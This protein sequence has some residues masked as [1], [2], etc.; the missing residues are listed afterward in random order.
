MTM[1]MPRCARW[2]VWWLVGCGCECSHSLPTVWSLGVVELS[3]H[4]SPPLLTMRTG[5]FLL[6]VVCLVGVVSAIRVDVYSDAACTKLLQGGN[7]APGC[8][9]GDDGG[10]YLNLQC[11]ASPQW[12]YTGAWHR[13]QRDRGARRTRKKLVARARARVAHCCCLSIASFFCTQF[14]RILRADARVH[15]RPRQPVRMPTRGQT[16][17]TTEHMCTD[18]HTRRERNER[19]PISCSTNAVDV[20]IHHEWSADTCACVSAGVCLLCLVASPCLACT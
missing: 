3:S 2:I 4:S 10:S 11:P 12:V 15:R 7:G 13:R 8:G 5:L 19:T 14:I 1:A 9:G 16:H 6:A 20:R 17:R 18:R